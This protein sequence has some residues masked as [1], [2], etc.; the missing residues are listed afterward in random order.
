M[1]DLKIDCI[2]VVVMR[3]ILLQY[4]I[5][6][7]MGQAKVEADEHKSIISISEQGFRF[8]NYAQ[9]LGDYAKEGGK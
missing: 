9:Q 7:E 2:D 1:F 3:R 6:L 4:A 8:I 5:D